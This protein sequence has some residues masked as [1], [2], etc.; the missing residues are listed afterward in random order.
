MENNMTRF[1]CYKLSDNGLAMTYITESLSIMIEARYNNENRSKIQREII[2][3][4]HEKLDLL[5]ISCWSERTCNPS[6][7]AQL[8][9]DLSP[10]SFEIPEYQPE[11]DNSRA[12][13]KLIRDYC[14]D[15]PYADIFEVGPNTIDNP[16]NLPDI[17]YMD[18]F[19]YP[20]TKESA[21][22]D[23]TIVKLFRQGMFSVLYMGTCNHE[24]DV[25]ETISNVGIQENVNVI[26]F[27][28]LILKGKQ[29]LEHSL[30]NSLKPQIIANIAGELDCFIKNESRRD[31]GEYSVHFSGAEGFLVK[32]G[33]TKNE[34]TYSCR[35]KE[36]FS[37]GQQMY[38][39]LK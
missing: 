15:N 26:V 37:G 38:I 22:D 4:G 2:L 9:I 30:I 32:Y 3:S 20:L 5:H 1:R 31:Q 33:K 29:I 17:D 21:K 10:I 13:L 23:K 11:D 36:E 16:S 35:D 27:S 14:K 7:L 34:E 39:Q 6:E 25:F 8:L 28:D 18:L 12:C 19:L 24:N